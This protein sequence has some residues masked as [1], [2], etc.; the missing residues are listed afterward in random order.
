MVYEAGAKEVH[1][2][3]SSPP[4]LY[5]DFYGINLPTQED[6]I[7]FRMNTDEIRDHL[8][9]HSLG[10]LSFDGMIRATGKPASSFTSHCFDGK[11]PIGIGSEQDKIVP[12]LIPEFAVAN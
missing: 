11:Y 2:L 12:V 4:V 3:I 8:G 7:A 10:Y 9:V 5:P 6:L 1:I